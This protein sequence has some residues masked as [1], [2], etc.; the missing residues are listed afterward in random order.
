MR[1][2]LVFTI[3]FALGVVAPVEAAVLCAP[4]GGDG[5]VKVREMCEK[6]ETQ[7][8]PVALGLQGPPGPPGPM[9]AQGPQGEQGV[10]GPQGLQG[11][12]GLPGIQGEKGDTGPPGPAAKT[13]AVYDANNNKVGDVISTSSPP[14]TAMIALQVDTHLLALSVNNN[15]IDGSTSGPPRFE[16]TNC[17]GAPLVEP[18]STHSIFPFVTVA[19]PGR[20]IY[21]PDP[22]AIPRQFRYRSELNPEGCVPVDDLLVGV[23]A[24][25]LLDL[26]TLFTPPFRVEVQE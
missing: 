15:A 11:E 13:F 2:L 6:N 24:S 9:G 14:A 26:N 4:K 1:C 8:D 7:L 25:V 22:A 21:L 16:S 20:T 12:R 23:P 18:G 17:L 19:P 10:T 3:F 5:S